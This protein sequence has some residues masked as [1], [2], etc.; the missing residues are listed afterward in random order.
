M[1]LELS[2][3]SIDIYLLCFLC[4]EAKRRRM[5]ATDDGETLV[6]VMISLPMSDDKF[7]T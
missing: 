1:I 7:L 2:I 4:D 6:G 3:C 5:V